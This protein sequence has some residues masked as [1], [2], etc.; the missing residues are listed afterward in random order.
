ML[1][2]LLRAKGTGDDRLSNPSSFELRQAYGRQY[3]Q[4]KPDQYF[5]ILAV[6]LRKFFISVTA[7]V[8][9]KNSSFQMAACLLVMFLAYSAQVMARPYMNAGEFE[10]V[11]RDHMQSSLTNVVHARIRKQIQSIEARGRKRVRKN[12]STL[13]AKWIAQLFLVCLLPG[14]LTTTRLSSS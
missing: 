11:L 1:D 3:F 5:W 6:I 14:S 12:L 7:V 10:D 8:F 4:F 2:Q 9:S 13:K